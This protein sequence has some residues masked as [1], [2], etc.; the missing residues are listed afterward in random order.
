[1]S[2]FTD[3]DGDRV[4]QVWVK[5]RVEDGE[6]RGVAQD[7]F[8]ARP[9]SVKVHPIMR[10]PAEPCTEQLGVPGPWHTRLTHF[11]MEYVP[12][13]GAELQSEYFVDRRHAIAAL[14]AIRGLR[15]EIAPVLQISE[16][17]TIAAD[18]LLLSPYNGRESV[19]FHFTWLPD[20]SAVA[21]ILPLLEERLAPFDARPHW[22]KLFT[23]SPER[24]H[25]LYPQLP[26]FAAL[27]RELDPTG[28]FRNP[29]LDRCFSAG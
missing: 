19:A 4:E 18:D 16:V 3:W 25:A 22:G 13:S 15:A 24:L 27:Q 2:L 9:A 7:F 17:R 26:A 8:G 10:L 21:P 1:V 20:W 14:D 11:R 23:T 29:F 6:T 5:R 12:S 28:K